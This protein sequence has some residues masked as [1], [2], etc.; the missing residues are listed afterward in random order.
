MEN[1]TNPFAFF[2][3]GGEMGNRIRNFNWAETP[4]GPAETWPSNLRNTLGL[5]MST[6]FP[7]FLFWGDDAVQFYNDGYI[8]ILNF[9]GRHPG[10]LGQKGADCWEDVWDIVGGLINTVRTGEDVYMENLM[11]NHRFEGARKDTYWT[12][13][14]SPVW[15]DSGNVDGVV[16]IC[17]ETTETVETLNNLNN[18]KE[19]LEFAIEAAELG[20]WDL[21]PATGEFTG[22]TRLKRWFGLAAEDHIPLSHATDVIDPKDRQRVIDSITLTMQAGEGGRYDEEYTINNPLTGN[23]IIVRALGRAWFKE[24]GTCYRFNGT[25]QDI[26]GKRNAQ[27]EIDDANQLAALATK[28]AGIGLFQVDLKTGDMEYNQEYVHILTGNPDKKLR[29]REDYLAYIIQDDM[30]ARAQA[31]AIGDVTNEYLY[32]VRTTWDDGTIHHLFVSGARTFDEN[33]IPLTFSGTVKD[34]TAQEEQRLELSRA[35]EQFRAMIETS[36]IGV[37]LWTGPDMVIE[38]ANDIMIDI[39]GKDRSVIGKPLAVAVPELVGQPFLGILDKIYNTGIAYHGIEEAADI[40]VNGVLSTYYYDFSYTPLFDENGKVY[41]IMDMAID[42]TERVKMQQHIQ[43]TQQ[44]ILASFDQAP[45]GIA[46]IEK[47]TLRFVMANPFYG[48]IVDRQP[49]DLVGKTLIEALPELKGQGI[50]ELLYG[51]INSGVAFSAKEFAVGLKR[52]DKVEEIYLDFI[53]QP[54]HD[55]DGVITGVL[56]VVTDVT[57]QVRSRKAIEDAQTVLRGAVE[58]AQLANWQMDIKNKTFYYSDRFKKWLGMPKS[59][60]TKIGDGSVEHIPEPYNQRV[61]QLLEEAIAPGSNGVYDYEHPVINMKTGQTRIIHAQ[62]QVLYDS[63][64]NPEFLTGTAQDVTK[65]R[66]LQQQLEYEVQQRTEELQVMNEELETTNEQLLLSNKELQQFAYIA[67]HDLQEPSRKISIFANM[68]KERLGMVDEKSTFYLDKISTSSDRMGTL[69]RDVLGYSQLSK[70]NAFKPVNL[71]KTVDELVI[72]FELLL[73]Q[74]NA[75]VEYNG[76]PEVEA[77]P[78]QMS[79]LFSNLVSNSLKYSREGVPPHIT[80]STELINGHQAGEYLDKEPLNATVYYR[81]QFKDNGIGFEQKYADKIFNIFQRLH[82]KD[83]YSGTGIGLAMCKKILQNHH[84]NIIAQSHEGQGALFTIII[85][86]KQEVREQVD[87][88]L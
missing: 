43:E 44:Q 64:G 76:L 33:G 7:M 87:F 85:P 58:L 49:A 37:C 24:D 31:L 6:K 55:K 14:Y 65:E 17:Q 42:V 36:P 32:N 23:K 46:L 27:R 1:T 54:Q 9:Q 35:Q 3:G 15:G 13:S 10:A 70:E 53:Y 2:K 41:A 74:Y 21:D 12:F 51:V 30:P 73:E 25:L 79:Q 69:I 18:G 68:L 34:V 5:M 60:E 78:L 83:E 63:Q 48:E 26:T 11:I 50:E 67:S 86:Q 4:V 61:K 19:E 75:R 8:K 52:G 56:V 47:S 45:V 29:K 77:I 28:S 20:I 40:E 81:I 82:S 16:V 80:I 22:N 59:Q 84:G 38:I 57:Q 88:N 72:E 71:A 39:W 66:K 62:A